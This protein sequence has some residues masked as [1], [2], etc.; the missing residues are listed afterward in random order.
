M[1]RRGNPSSAL[2]LTLVA[3]LA[4]WSNEADAFGVG[5]GAKSTTTTMGMG[6]SFGRLFRI[7]TW[8]ESHGGG[9]GVNLDGCPPKI[10]LTAQDIQVELDRRKPGQ[11]RITTPRNEDDQVEILSGLSPEGLTLGTPIA[12]LVRN[13][14]RYSTKRDRL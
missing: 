7:S 11:S 8:G 10:P 14:V 2:A 12:M 9:V 1:A 6:N 5:M 3:T 13:K 4:L